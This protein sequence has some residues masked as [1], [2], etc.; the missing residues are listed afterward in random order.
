MKWCLAVYCI[1]FILSVVVIILCVGECTGWLPCTFEK[2]LN[3]YAL[4]AVLL[5]ASAVIIWPIFQ[6]DSKYGGTTRRPNS[7]SNHPRMLCTWDKLVAVA[8]LSSANL[9]VYIIDL[10]YSARLIFITV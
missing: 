9:I 8:V 1:C 6:F 3:A 5:Y 10:V 7:C 4:L 2:F